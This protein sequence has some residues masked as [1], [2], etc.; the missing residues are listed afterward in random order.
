[1]KTLARLGQV[2]LY[3]S[4]MKRSVEFYQDRLGLPVTYPGPAANLDEAHWVTLDAGG[5]SLALHS[6]GTPN[7]DTLA[8]A[9][10]FLVENLDKAYEDVMVHGVKLSEI[11]E[12]HPGTRLCHGTDP[13]GHT[14]FIKQ[15]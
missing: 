7:R 9:V 1:M 15:A 11:A 3:V 2:I 5:F 6:G 8:P 14:Y 10:V 12:P 4:E 13:D